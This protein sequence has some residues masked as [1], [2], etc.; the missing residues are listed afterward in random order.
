M[1][2]KHLPWWTHSVTLLGN[3]FFKVL[4][5]SVFKL[6]EY[7]MPEGPKLP[8]DVLEASASCSMPESPSSDRE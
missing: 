5:V 2:A 8:V 4:D 3:G 7:M 6:S 1:K